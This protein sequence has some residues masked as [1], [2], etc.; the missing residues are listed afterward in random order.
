MKLL[1]IDSSIL[2]A[3]SVSRELSRAT[4][5][6]LKDLNPE[7]DVTYRDLVAAPVPH[8]TGDHLAASP[9]VAQEV[10]L[11]EEILDEFMNADVIVIGIAFYNLTISS[12]L[13]AWID[14]IVIAGKTFRYTETGVE[15]LARDKR[16]IL[17]VARRRTV[18]ARRFPGPVRACGSLSSVDVRIHRRDTNRGGRGGRSLPRRSPKAKRQAGGFRG[19]ICAGPVLRAPRRRLTE[20]RP[21]PDIDGRFRQA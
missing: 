16:I 12:Q 11:G 5:Q 15:G 13:K 2:G 3:H 17:A 8:L 18:P 1:H 14:R 21:F 10:A 7:T 20:E 19:H 6:R 4:V 9:A